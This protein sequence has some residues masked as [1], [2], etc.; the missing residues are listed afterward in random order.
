M[1]WNGQSFVNVLWIW[2]TVIKKGDS[3]TDSQRKADDYLNRIRKIETSIKEKNLELEALRYKASGAGAIDYS[4]D[5]VQT[6]PK[7]YMEMAMCD[8]VEILARIEEDKAS[9][10]EIKANAYSIIRRIDDIS[11][12]TILEWF[13]ING[14]DMG[15]ISLKMFL[16]ERATYY[17]KEDALSSFSALMD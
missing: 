12:R 14:V 17:L 16:S 4:K 11:Q 9:I 6:S 13:Y 2:S 3:M 5:R 8:I 15:E 1:L 7:N 10:E